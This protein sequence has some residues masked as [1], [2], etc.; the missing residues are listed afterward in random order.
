VIASVKF[1]QANLPNCKVDLPQAFLKDNM[2]Q[3]L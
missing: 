1:V 3:I 2:R